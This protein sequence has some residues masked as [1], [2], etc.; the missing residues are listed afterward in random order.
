MV[1]RPE[2]LTLT[3]FAPFPS[4]LVALRL[5]WAFRHGHSAVKCL[6]CW[7]PGCSLLYM[8][9]VEVQT[10]VLPLTFLLFNQTEPSPVLT[11]PPGFRWLIYSL[12]N[13][14]A[15]FGS[16]PSYPSWPLC[17]LP[18]LLVWMRYQQSFFFEPTG[19]K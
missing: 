18:A 4:V 3:S 7:F 1:K 10:F 6:S 5:C 14:C 17:C 2:T 15:R 19:K 8:L 11:F 9:P 12:F 16:Y 13:L